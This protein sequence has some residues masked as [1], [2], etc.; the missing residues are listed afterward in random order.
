MP[1]R[2]RASRPRCDPEWRDR[3]YRN[4]CAVRRRTFSRQYCRL[5]VALAVRCPGNETP[6]MRTTR[7]SRQSIPPRSIF[8]GF[9]FPPEVIVVAVRWYPRASVCPMATSWNSSPS[10]ASRSTTSP[11]TDGYCGSRHC[12][13]TPRDHAATASAI[14]G[15][16]TRPT[17]RS[18]GGGGTSTERSA[19]SARSSTCSSRPAG[20]PWRPAGSLSKPSARP[21]PRRWRSPTGAGVSG[22]PG[23]AAAGGVAPHRAVWQQ[24]R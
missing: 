21:R 2:D 14:A 5:T 1:D 7:P 20:T 22:G 13:P 6:T 11:S 12:W 15:T 19:S 8:A 16:S 23:G 3:S 18:P 17:S 4:H 10:A 9:R 24:P